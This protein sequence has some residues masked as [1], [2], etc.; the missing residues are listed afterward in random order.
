[1]DFQ[2]LDLERFQESYWLVHTYQLGDA[3]THVVEQL[4]L[5]VLGFLEL[6]FIKVGRGEFLVKSARMLKIEKVRVLGER[7]K[8]YQRFLDLDGDVWSACFPLS[9]EVHF[10]V[11]GLDHLRLFLVRFALVSKVL[12]I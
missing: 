4:V 11:F 2:L 9:K 10:F 12:L 7:G 3:S 6:I 8:F 1:M 5:V